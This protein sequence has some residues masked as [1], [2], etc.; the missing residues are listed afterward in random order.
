M[1]FLQIGVVD[2]NLDA[3]TLNKIVTSTLGHR[4]ESVT[5]KPQLRF[6][7]AQVF[8][9]MVEKYIPKKTG[10]LRANGHVVS[11]GHGSGDAR[12]RWYATNRGYDYATD[13]FYTQYR[14]YTTAGTGPNWT[15]A[16]INNEWNTYLAAIE[17]IIMRAFKEGLEND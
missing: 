12:L 6:E 17:P 15:G 16:L 2:L 1:S 5:K 10:N 11:G 13:Q 3:R 7:V 9:D 8:L 4:A 14:N